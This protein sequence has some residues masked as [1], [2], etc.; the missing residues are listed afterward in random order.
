MTK[1]VKMTMKTIALIECGCFNP[2]TFLHL[3]LFETARDALT[4]AGFSVPVGI[5]SPAHDAY[6]KK[7][8]LPAVH[9]I[10]MCQLAVKS[11]DWITCEVWETEQEGWTRTSNVLDHYHTLLDRKYPGLCCLNFACFSDLSLY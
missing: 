2:P 11:S 7:G 8:L 10:N 9:R 1:L 3:R 6:G 5:I 4:K